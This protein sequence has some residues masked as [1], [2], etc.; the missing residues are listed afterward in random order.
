MWEKYKT[1][2]TFIGCLVL[3]YICTANL[4]D[5]KYA[6]LYSYLTRVN[7]TCSLMTLPFPADLLDQLL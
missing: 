1:F 3:K 6:I 4:M 7:T 2:D 5:L